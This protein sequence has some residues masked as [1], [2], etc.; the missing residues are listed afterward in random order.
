MMNAQDR[1]KFKQDHPHY[2]DAIIAVKVIEKAIENG[3]DAIP[4]KWQD[5]WYVGCLN[6]MGRLFLLMDITDHEA[7]MAISYLEPYSIRELSFSPAFAKAL[8]GSEDCESRLKELVIAEDPFKYLGDY[9]N[10]S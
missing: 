1:V 3:W 2:K 6:M 9:L 8:F 10:A 7:Q 4:E 5:K